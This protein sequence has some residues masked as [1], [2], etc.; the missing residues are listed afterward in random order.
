MKTLLILRHAKSSW[1]HPGLRDHDR[2]LNPRGRRDAPRMGRFLVERDLVP[3][4]IVSSTAVRARTT[5]ELAAAEF[6]EDV[7]IETTY[8]LYGASPDGYVEVA[9]AMGGT[10]ERL[11]LVGHNPGITSL[12]WHLTGEGEYMPT[13]ALTAVELD[14]DDW[15]ELGTRPA[16]AGLTGFWR[17]KALPPG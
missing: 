16:A 3:D 17:P 13:A 6:G 11:M 10:A 12:V 8:D 1:D 4:R 15:S 2:P 5:A 7:E 9:E 14:I